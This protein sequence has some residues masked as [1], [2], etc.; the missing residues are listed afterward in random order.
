MLAALA[1]ARGRAWRTWF[2]AVVA[3]GAV[4]VSA[5]TPLLDAAYHLLPGFR[6]SRPD[7][8]VFLYM[9][10]VSV[11][12]AFGCVEATG[13]RSEV[14]TASLPAWLALGG[15]AIAG[16]LAA[17]LIGTPEMRSA[18][19]RFGHAVLAFVAAHPETLVWTLVEIALMAS[20][21][22]AVAVRPVR[23]VRIRTALILVALCVPLFRFGWRFNPTQREPV[24]PSHPI[25]QVV[26]S[27]SGAGAGRLARL[28]A[29]AGLAWPANTAQ[30]DGIA[31]V[32][33]ASAA[34]LGAYA[35]LIDAADPGAVLLEKSFPSFRSETGS[36]RRLL[37]LLSVRYLLTERVLP[38]PE[39]W[40]DPRAAIR[41]YENPSAL[42]RFF[43]VH[44]V[45]LYADE[46]SARRRALDSSF[47]LRAAA[48]VRLGQVS[49]LAGDGAGPPAV[50]RVNRDEPEHIAM[51]VTTSSPGLL[52]T[53]DA[54]YPGWRARVD[55][56]AA[57]LVIANTAFRSVP[58]PAGT[59]EVQFRF[60][61]D[62]LHHGAMLSIV[63]LVALLAL[64]R[65][66]GG[67]SGGGAAGI[68]APP[69]ILRATPATRQRGMRSM[70]HAGT[71]WPGG[72]ARRTR[73]KPCFW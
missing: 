57:P 26:G 34:M 22:L 55:G 43:V 3:L 44:R 30:L 47:D 10:A 70:D 39:R 50:I 24:L 1:L 49:G 68:R 69:R 56:R 37:D 25:A 58:V 27:S 4:G 64:L 38:L 28:G 54:Y 29:N 7:R 48:L 42:P 15:V 36:V 53:S 63:S 19:V 67:G 12:A 72:S 21:A 13:A 59:H 2:F 66:S 20:A 6:F 46:V 51:T 40:R 9:V 73:S 71:A 41:I 16:L 62:S 32:N 11:L 33:G 17:L 45:E 18:Y 52:V 8:I 31:D 60:Q 35:A 61:S 65:R 5:G 14:R 23:D